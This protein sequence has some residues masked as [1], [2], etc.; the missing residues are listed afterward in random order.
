M[1]YLK[2]AQKGLKANN[3]EEVQW[4]FGDIFTTLCEN[5]EIAKDSLNNITKFSSNIWQVHP[6]QEGNTRTTAIFIQ[7]YLIS[8]GFKVNNE[9]FKD[10]SYKDFR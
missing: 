5:K 9:L 1:L 10:N 2:K 6:F 8:M 3:V 7:K 4:W